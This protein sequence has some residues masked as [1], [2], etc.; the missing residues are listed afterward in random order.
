[1]PRIKD[2]S[3][4]EQ[5]TEMVSKSENSSETKQECLEKREFKQNLIEYQNK[6]EGK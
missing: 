6:M 2:D 4:S 5:D 3:D 1:M